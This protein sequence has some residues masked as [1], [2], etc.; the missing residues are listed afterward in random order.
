MS[1]YWNGGTYFK[2]NPSGSGQCTPSC[3][4]HCICDSQWWHDASVLQNDCHGETCV[5]QGTDHGT[6]LASGR[7]AA[8][9]HPLARGA[10]RGERQRR[11]VC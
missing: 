4:C 6:E 5:V 2:Y 7:G 10:A 9:V 8:R 3:K 11:A 1:Y